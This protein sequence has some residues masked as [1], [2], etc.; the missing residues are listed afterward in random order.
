MLAKSVSKLF[1]SD[2]VLESLVFDVSFFLLDNQYVKYGTG[3]GLVHS[4][5]LADACYYE[6]VERHMVLADYHIKY[7]A[8]FRDDSLIL[9]EDAGLFRKLH[10]KLDSLS[11]FIVLKIE[12]VSLVA[13]RFVDI[14]VTRVT[15][16][17]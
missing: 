5:D 6:M 4:G 16:N 2:P 17:L 12:E 3:I 9:A 14:L 15:C 7:Y 13:L 1:A 8:R 11:D 10:D